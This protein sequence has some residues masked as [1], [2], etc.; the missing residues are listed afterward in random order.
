[1]VSQAP[2]VDEAATAVRPLEERVQD[3][4]ARAAEVLPSAE[5]LPAG[6]TAAVELESA[7]MAALTAFDK[8]AAL[9]PGG[10]LEPLARTALELHALR[11]ELRERELEARLTALRRVQEALSRL[12]GVATVE[13]LLH[14]ATAEVCRTCGF[15]RAMLFR[16]VGSE[17]V[18]VSVHFDDDPDWAARVLELAQRQRPQL[19][20]MLLE[21]EMVRRRGATIVLDPANDPRTFKPL[22]EAVQ[23]A[24][25]VA[26]PIMPEG[27]VIGFLHADRHASDR[28]VTPL[29][30]DTLWTFAEGFGYAVERTILLERLRTQRE[31][32]HQLV[33]STEAV[34]A[35][36]ADAELEL[37]HAGD[38]GAALVR[39][40]PAVLRPAARSW[41]AC[42]PPGSARCWR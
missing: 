33:A 41:R 34:L 19:N 27:R 6:S 13:R 38:E 17:M 14:R 12:R 2:P 26:A 10:R 18:A 25:Y 20:H 37:A 42:S 1:M 39:T 5:W 21:T 28:E 16:L 15:D 29:D 8:Q 36:L 23:T 30:R 22:V 24:S 7:V 4:L 31:R 3:A 35:E 32:C 11:D 9:E 40:A